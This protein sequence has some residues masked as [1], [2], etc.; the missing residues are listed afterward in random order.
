LGARAH[1][2][3]QGRFHVTT[4]DVRAVARPVL[5]HRLMTSYAA[6]SQGMTPD[7]VIE[8]LLKTVPVE[9]HEREKK[10]VQGE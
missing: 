8:R 7:A 2:L 6:A 3:L 5:R 4:E 9:L 10:R 1:A